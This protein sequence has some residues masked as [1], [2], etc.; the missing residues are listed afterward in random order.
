MQG[1][2]AASNWRRT[3]GSASPTDTGPT[4]LGSTAE[5]VRRTRSAIRR[6]EFERAGLDTCL[7]LAGCRRERPLPWSKSGNGVAARCFG[8][9]D[10]KEFAC[11]GGGALAAYGR[12]FACDAAGDPPLRAPGRARRMAAP[13]TDRRQSACHRVRYLAAGPPPPTTCIGA[14]TPR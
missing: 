13:D 10:G 4:R 1:R 8:W 6:L 11:L 14:D 5:T 12:P 2:A 7:A 3:I 9:I